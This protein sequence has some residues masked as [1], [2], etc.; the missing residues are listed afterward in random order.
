MKFYEF[1]K[2]ENPVIFLF[3]ER[4]VIGRQISGK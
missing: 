3:R 2:K 4:A 1:G